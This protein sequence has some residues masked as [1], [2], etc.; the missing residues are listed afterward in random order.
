MA[1]YRIATNPSRGPFPDLSKNYKKYQRINQLDF[2]LISTKK[3]LP[4]ERIKIKYIFTGKEP[5]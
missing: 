3:L 2:S 4:Q 5:S 1:P